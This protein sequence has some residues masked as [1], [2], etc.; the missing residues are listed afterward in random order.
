MHPNLNS[1]LPRSA[2]TIVIDPGLPHDPDLRALTE[3]VLNG[4][5]YS[6]CVAAAEDGTDAPG[7]LDRAFQEFVRSQNPDK[8]SVSRQRA[9]DLLRAPAP[10]R[11][12]EFGAFA[13][14]DPVKYK[15]IG[16]EAT[17]RTIVKDTWKAPLQP[18]WKHPLTPAWKVPLPVSQDVKA[19]LA[20]KRLRLTV[21]RV[22]CL[23]E[24]SGFGSDEIN[25]GGTK[26]DPG[27]KTSLVKEFEIFDDFD[28]GEVIYPE[29]PK[30]KNKVF[31]EWNLETTL[32]GYPYV[33]TA[34]IS[35]AEK[36]DGGFWKFLKKVWDKV[37]TYVTT[38]IAAGIGSLAGSVFPGIGTVVGA[39]VGA[40]VGWLI[41]VL[42]DNADDIVDTHTLQL[43][44]EKANKSHYDEL[45]L[46]SKWGRPVERFFEGDGGR[47]KVNFA[48]HVL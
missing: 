27:G 48:Y 2:D 32:G 4:L 24:T 6:Y 8:R 16:S 21:T 5:K 36:D 40:F 34:V 25:M 38:A 39:V 22:E 29:H 13:T 18:K 14:I 7:E 28:E 15:A 19:G 33:Y 37:D 47:Y 20:F 46:T 31:A 9:Q 26:V 45:K 44:L 10:A 30:K 17:I 11:A 1:K 35:M 41:S 12:G 42:G 23:D 3:H 43:T